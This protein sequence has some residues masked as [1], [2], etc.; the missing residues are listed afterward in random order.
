MS[1]DHINRSMYSCH[2]YLCTCINCSIDFNSF[3]LEL[4]QLTQDD[5]QK[6]PGVKRCV[7][8]AIRLRSPGVIT[9]GVAKSFDV[10]VCGPMSA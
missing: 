5:L 8:E 7:L 10:R 1:L 2:A 6:M 9:R 3:A 4:S